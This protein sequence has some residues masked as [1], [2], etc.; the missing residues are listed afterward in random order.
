MP[1][2]LKPQLAEQV[3]CSAKAELAESDVMKALECCSDEQMFHCAVCPNFDKHDLHKQ[4]LALLR[5]K[6]A[7]IERLH[8][9]LAEVN[10]LATEVRN[11]LPKAYR[12][13]RNNTIT[14]F[15]ERAKRRLPII[16]P[17]VF[18]QIAKEMKGEEQ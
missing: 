2:E 11:D 10:R 5:E 6:D 17:S 7:E 16:S 4:A 13:K 12:E 9:I 3:T 15:A 14:E 1:N 18:D 8:G